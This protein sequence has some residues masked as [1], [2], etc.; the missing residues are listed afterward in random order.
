MGILAWIVLG[1]FAG[2]VASLIMG[3]RMGLVLSICVGIVGAL[4]GGMIFNYFGDYG[5]TGFN[6]YSFMVATVG[7][8]ILLAI[9][10]LLARV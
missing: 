7:S 6:L 9:A 3:G 2:W 1:G 8:V 10:R 4:L 5:V